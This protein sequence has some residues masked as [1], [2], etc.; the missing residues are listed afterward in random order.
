VGI[1]GTEK[2]PAWR[3]PFPLWRFQVRIGQP[4]IPPIPEGR[5]NHQALASVGDT[6][7]QRIAGLLAEECRGA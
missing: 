1:I 6:I 4:F 7:M 3:M 2:F 5:V